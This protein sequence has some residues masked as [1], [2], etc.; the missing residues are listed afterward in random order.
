MK[1]G[2]DTMTTEKRKQFLQTLTD[3][4]LH[5]CLIE[6]STR[7]DRCIDGRKRPRL[8]RIIDLIVAEKMR[9]NKKESTR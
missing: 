3:N 2:V 6:T 8:Q 9:R 5:A 7:L 4:E 1:K